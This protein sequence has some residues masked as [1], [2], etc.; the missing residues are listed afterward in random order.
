M[1]EHLLIAVDGSAE[2]NEA[3]SQGETA[4]FAQAARME[5]R[6]LLDACGAGRRCE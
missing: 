6:A 2:S 5:A 1:S 3:M 4:A